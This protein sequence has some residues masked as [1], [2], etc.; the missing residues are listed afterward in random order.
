MKLVVN[1][2]HI[3]DGLA[4]S[5]TLSLTWYLCARAASGLP[6][7]EISPLRFY[8]KVIKV[9][10][11]VAALHIVFLRHQRCCVRWRGELSSASL[12]FSL[13]G[14]SVCFIRVSLSIEISPFLTANK[15]R[16]ALLFRLNSVMIRCL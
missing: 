10:A 12:P 16:P 8:E 4:P 3:F 5:K 11:D 14:F 7:D 2:K 6:T 9:K 15:T 13:D 1:G